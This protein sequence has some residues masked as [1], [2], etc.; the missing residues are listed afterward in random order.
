MAKRSREKRRSPKSPQANCIF[1][2]GKPV[3]GEHLISDWIKRVLPRIHERHTRAKRVRSTEASDALQTVLDKAK[4]QEGNVASS[5]IRSVCGPCNYGWM[6]LIEDAAI[7]V[8]A[9][10]IQGAPVAITPDAQARI[11]VWATLKTIIGES[12]N[13]SLAAI[14]IPVVKEFGATRGFPANMQ[15]WIGS[16]NGYE[17]YRYSHHSIFDIDDR[18]TLTDT[19]V[20]NPGINDRISQTTWLLMGK[21]LLHTYCATQQHGSYRLPPHFPFRQVHPALGQSID[22]PF[23]PQIDDAFMQY[24]I[25]ARPNAYRE[26]QA[27]RRRN[28][29]SS[30]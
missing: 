17:D 18:A 15:V 25:T 16:Y 8:L 28:P 12:A 22:W 21:L 30:G 1:C 3:T 10:M 27:K 20:L 19:G 26:A 7:P 5:R 6:K 4:R 14:P 24:L 11:A 23:Q 2:G 29:A 13:K 9:P